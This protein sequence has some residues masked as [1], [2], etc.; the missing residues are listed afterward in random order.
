VIHPVAAGPLDSSPLDVRFT[1]KRLA[2]SGLV[3]VGFVRF[4]V[5]ALTHGL[6]EVIGVSE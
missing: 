3:P 6:N 5:A 1:G 2:T 4:V